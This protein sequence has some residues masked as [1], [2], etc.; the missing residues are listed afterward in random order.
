VTAKLTPEQRWLEAE[1][2]LL[3]AYN[4]VDTW[5]T[6]QLTPILINLLKQQGQWDF[7]EREVWTQLPAVLAMQERGIPF[8]QEHKTQYRKALRRE[9]REIDE[10][11]YEHYL[12]TAPLQEMAW[13]SVVQLLGW[14]GYL[15]FSHTTTNLKALRRRDAPYTKGERKKLVPASYD[16]E[17]KFTGKLV[18]F[19][20][21]DQMKQWLFGDLGLK[22][23]GVKTDGDEESISQKALAAI[24]KGLRK[25]DEPH[26]WVV[27]DLMHRARLDHIDSTYLDPEVKDGFVYPSL[28]MIGTETGRF[29]YSDPP[30]HS[31]SERP[32]FDCKVNGVEVTIKGVQ[33]CIV[34]PPGYLIV[35]GDYSAMEARIFANVTNDREE[36]ELFENARL[37]PNNKH[38][39]I[40]IRNVCGLF[41]WTVEQF[42]EQ[43]PAYQ[44]MIRTGVG[45]VF[46]FGVKQYGGKPTSVKTKD[47]CVCPRCEHPDTISFTK[48]QKD[49][50]AKRWFQRHPNV[51][52][53]RRDMSA[54]V[55]RSHRGT[56]AAGQVR[57][58]HTPWSSKSIPCDLDKERWNFDI[59]SMATVILRRAMRRLHEA[60]VAL[61]LEWHD[62]LKALARE[63]EA[64]DVAK[65]MKVEMERPV[66]EFGGFVF[67]V[68]IE[69]GP[70]LGEMKKVH[71]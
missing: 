32:A 69:V 7:W 67:P 42:L 6:A 40:H 25:K 45:K 65:L 64:L 37:D 53:W 9:L 61:F 50:Q 46:Q 54:E 30:V 71:L 8:S 34:A 3:G 43:S 55:K 57:Y 26:R 18:N 52:R 38:Y 63:S 49:L 48:E 11:L 24:H 62:S 59:Q 39:D 68:E 41:G 13:N 70:S 58:F 60:G 47:V 21:P 31:W 28:K 16:T 19:G 14:L 1:D 12:A 44:K 35:G 20:S 10:K 27:E 51:L 22:S 56:N 23:S 15:N 33:G 4:C 5:A 17:G 2:E 36:L 66:P 29:A